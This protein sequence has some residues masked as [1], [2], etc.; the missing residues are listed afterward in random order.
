MREDPELDNLRFVST[1]QIHLFTTYIHVT[2][3]SAH[4]LESYI[5]SYRIG[6]YEGKRKNINGKMLLV[7][8]LSFVSNLLTQKKVLRTF[9]EN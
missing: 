5:K 2:H 8:A 3:L 6:Y 7:V 1:K 4:Q 9:H